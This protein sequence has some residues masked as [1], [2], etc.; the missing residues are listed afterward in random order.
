MTEP[1]PAIPSEAVQSEAVQIEQLNELSMGFVA[2]RCLHVVAE[3]GV[4]DVLGDVPE[5]P[6]RLAEKVAVNGDA[7]A[8][9]MRMLSRHG[10]FEEQDDGRFAHSPLSRLARSDHPRSQHPW[11][12]QVGSN[13]IWTIFSKLGHAVRSGKPAVGL[14][15]PPGLFPYF[16]KHP[17]EASVFNAGMASK[18]QG[19]IAAMLK[20]YDFTPF[21]TIGDIGGGRGHL[22]TAILNA[23]PKAKGVLFDQPAVVEEAQALRSER[24]RLMAG[25]FFKDPLPACDCYTLMSV[26]HDWSDDESIAILRAVR[27]AAPNG[28]RL[29]LCELV[30]PERSGSPYALMMD[31]AMLATAGGR[32]RKLSQYNALLEASGWRLERTI[33]TDVSIAIVEST[34]A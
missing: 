20:A 17:E 23:A 29:L 22:L 31:I 6:E 12:R 30:L 14:L 21:A 4:A 16:A 34:T 28:A 7:L 5:T 13:L 26:I 24:L 1:A 33:P 15:D 3:L 9:I 2:S 27:K 8:R 10:V 32:E 18:S 19:D 25:D 11:I